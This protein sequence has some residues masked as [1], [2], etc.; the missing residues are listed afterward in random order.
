MA[1]SG[2]TVLHN[3]IFR[4]YTGG[5]GASLLG[6]QIWFIGLAWAAGQL[7][8]AE[9]TSLVLA[10]GS[11][12]RAVLLLAGGAAA[13]RY[14]A[15]RVALVS[16]IGR[17]ALMLGGM[18]GILLLH[19]V[20]LWLLILVAGL[21]GIADAF[22]MPA[23]AALPP[24]FLPRGQLPAGQGVVQ[25]LE[26]GA[27]V[28]GAPLG[29]F[30]VA[31]GGFS[32]ALAANALLFIAAFVVLRSLKRPVSNDT[33]NS[34]TPSN[35]SFWRSLSG[36]FR[37]VTQDPVLAWILIVVTLLNIGLAGPLNV[38]LVLLS[39]QHGWSAAEY[40]WVLSAFAAGAVLGAVAVA[41][42]KTVRRPALVGLAWVIMG[43]TALSAVPW[44]DHIPLVM[45][46]TASTGF[47]FGPGTA[48]L[49]GLVQ[50]RTDVKHLGRVMALVN[51]SALGLA[52]IS[53]VVFGQAASRLGAAPT[54]TGFSALVVITALI[55]GLVPSLRRVS[56]SDRT[57]QEV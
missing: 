16:Q 20:D 5:F 42:R 36:G 25:T 48:L 32:L 53:Y 23:E 7:G 13:D 31:A 40:S 8:S 54:F 30:L 1:D 21:F 34:D 37:Y 10:V 9:Q 28:A 51:F 46:A 26:R 6:D 15:L 57:G 3:R 45:L 50:S 43:G 2:N 11:I 41:T 35:E 14:G 19:E 44:L 39:K 17:I 27:L 52:P 29:G 12:P 47:A 56:L 55:A 22:H 49:I 33:T 4:R 18:A 38:G 24:Q